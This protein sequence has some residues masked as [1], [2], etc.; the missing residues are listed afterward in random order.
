MNRVEQKRYGYEIVL[1]LMLGIGAVGWGEPAFSLP[2]PSRKAE[3]S[4]QISIRMHNY[5]EGHRDT[6]EHAEREVARI[7]REVGIEISWV[8]CPLTEAELGLYSACLEP[9]H[10]LIFDMNVVPRFMAMRASMPETSLGFTSLTKEGRA[11]VATVFYDSVK[12]MAEPT[13]PA[14]T[15]ILAY[16]MAHELGHLLLPNSGHSSG[17]IMRA[18]W[19]PEDLRNAV[20]GKLF[21][22]SGQGKSMRAEV[23]ARA[24]KRATLADATASK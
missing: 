2:K 6:V 12:D 1:W 23:R 7:F 19:T 8:S 21:F 13:A 3:A 14:L 16:A 17:G 18:R 4:L 15:A 5:A 9:A 11:S 10:S 20:Y 22:T 24:Q